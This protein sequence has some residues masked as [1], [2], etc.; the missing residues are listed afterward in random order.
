MITIPGYNLIEK[1]HK[2][3]RTIVYRA[4]RNIDNQYVILKVLVNDSK[5]S[6][7]TARLQREFNII[8][9]IDINEVAQVYGLENY[10]NFTVLVLEDIG[11]QS[12]AQYLIHSEYDLKSLLKIA[13]RLAEIVG[14]IHQKSII[15]KDLKPANIIFNQDKNILKIIDFSISSEFPRESV[16]KR[17]FSELEG[18][19]TYSSP[20]QTGWMNRL[21]DYR[22]DFYTLGVT[23]YQM[24]TGIL[25]FTSEDPLELIHSHLARE[26]V[27]PGMVNS[28]IP[29]ILSLI[30][31]KL[32]SKNPED[33][34]K[35]AAGLKFDLDKCIDQLEKSGQISIFTIGE[36]D[37]SGKFQ[38]PEKL[39][40]RHEQQEMLQNAY[41]RISDKN[42]EL[43][44]ISG[45]PGIGKSALVKQ[46]YKPVVQNSG[47][48]ISGKFEQFN[49]NIPY[50]AFIQAFEDLINQV[51][52]RSPEKVKIWKDKLIQEFGTNLGVI[53]SMV[54]KLELITGTQT[55]KES[56]SL[57]EVQN[58]FNLVM[59]NF[60]GIIATKNNP[61]V[62]FIDDLQ[63]A[64]SSSLKLL[65]ILLTNPE[66]NHILFICAYRTGE[67]EQNPLV[68][69]TIIKINE[70]R[71][72]NLL[73]SGRDLPVNQIS[74]GKIETDTIAEMIQDTFNC[75]SKDANILSEIVS[76]Q[77]GGNPF[78]V[79]QFL[80]AIYHEGLFEFDTINSKWKWDLGKI[81]KAGFTDNIIQ[82]MAENFKKRSDETARILKIASCIGIKF[83]L[84]TLV[85]I[86]GKSRENT[87]HELAKAIR[88][89]FI[90][91]INEDESDSKNLQFQFQHDQ[92]LY[93]ANSLL[94]F[95]E[96]ILLHID[97]GEYNL[98]K[99]TY[100]NSAIFSNDRFGI[101]EN[102]GN[103]SINDKNLY[104]LQRLY[105]S[106]IFSL[107]NHYNSGVE[108]I[109]KTRAVTGL[110][111]LNFLA[112][113]QARNN[114]AFGTAVTYLNF[115][116]TILLENSWKDLYFITL[117]VYIESAE[118]EYINTNFKQAEEICNMVMKNAREVI[119]KIRIFEIIIQNLT[120]Q[121]RF[122]DAIE[123]GRSALN[124]LGVKLPEKPGP[125][126]ALPNIISAYLK[127]SKDVDRLTNL[128]IMNDP[129]K[130]A[131]MDIMVQLITP[132]FISVP[133]L[134]P[135]LILKMI[136]LTLK[137][138]LAPQTPYALAFF[139]M[140]LG[141]G[142]GKYEVGERLANTALKIMEIVP[143]EIYSCKV[144]FA[145]GNMVA[146][147]K[148]PLKDS[149]NILEMGYHKGL[150]SG[151]LL[152]ASY[153]LNWF[154]AY[155]YLTRKNLQQSL[156]E[157]KHYKSSQ[158][159]IKQKDAADFY[160]LWIQFVET[161]GENS[162]ITGYLKG[163][164]FDE[165]TGV[166]IWE[167]TNNNTDLFVYFMMKG[168]LNYFKA[169]FTNAVIFFEEAIPH[170]SGVFGMPVNAEHN[171]FYSLSLLG[172]VKIS[173]GNEKKKIFKKI[174]QNQ[175]K[176]FIWGKNSPENYLHKYLII[177]GEKK[178]VNND[179]KA[180]PVFESAIKTAS[181]NSFILEQAIAN[182]L[183][184]YYYHSHNNIFISEAYLSEA[185]RLYTRWGIP[186]KT[187]LLE[188]EFPEL[189]SKGVLAGATKSSSSADSTFQSTHQTIDL[190]TVLKVSQ[191]I[192]SEIDLDKLT[193]K[194]VLIAIENAGADKG[195]LILNRDK[196]LYLMAEGIKENVKLLDNIPMETFQNIAQ[197]VINYSK[198]TREVV[199]INDTS[200]PNQFQ[201]DPYIMSQKPM[202]IL[203]L[204]V[205]KQLSLIG[206]LYLENNFLTNAFTNERLAMINLLSTQAIISL[207]NAMYVK[208]IIS[209]NKQLENEI[210]D[211]KKTENEL[212]LSKE[213]YALAA[214][215]A[216]DGLWDWDLI[217]ENIYYS[218]R[219]IDMLGYAENEIEDSSGEWF[220]RVHIEDL[221]LLQS[222]IKDHLEGVLPLLECEYRMQHRDGRYLW[223]ITR[224]L[225]IRD[226]NNVAYRMAG[227][228]TEI[229]KR[230]LAEEQLKHDALFDSLTELPNWNLLLD[231]M[232]HAIKGKIRQAE[233]IFAVLFLDVDR[234]KVINDSLGHE[235]GNQLLKELARKL[236][237]CLRPE[238]TVAR[239]G[240][241]E[242]GILLENISD[243]NEPIQIIN[244]IRDST[245]GA[246]HILGHELFIT[247][248]IGVV[249]NTGD[250]L[251]AQDLIRDADTAMHRAKA[252]G[253]NRY[254]IFD[255]T[256]H[257]NI[258]GYLK[259]EGELRKALDK[260][261][262]ILYYQPIVSAKSGKIQGAEAL[263]RWRM[264]S[265]EIIPPGKFIP[266]AEET[267]LILQIGEWVLYE[268]C[269]EIKKWSKNG[270]TDI[271]MSVNI[272][273]N[274]FAQKNFLEIID[275]VISESGINPGILQVEMT[276]SV[277]M[278]NI[279]HATMVLNELKNR[280]IKIAI[281]DFGTGYSSLSYLK[282]F[283]VHKLKIDK[284]FIT[285]MV[286]NS[287][288]AAL[289]KAI[290]AMSESLYMKTIA[291]GVETLEQ[292]QMLRKNQCS[293]I[294][295]YYFSKPVTSEEFF[296]LFRNSEYFPLPD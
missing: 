9:S 282:Q 38:I 199:V 31:L 152:F 211:H 175:K 22:T 52:T 150:N 164:F 45:D 14:K 280:G 82:L 144:Y 268:A 197:G 251:R 17:I 53:S 185:Y 223:M 210:D 46:M 35:T 26:P 71:K 28:N 19:L 153:S 274:Q 74:L 266:L 171:F 225:A 29:E 262:F 248:S 84:E 286:S 83:D 193:Q 124:E 165:D 24:F 114:I 63:W 42:S 106:H 214:R 204:P 281:D 177:E 115:A 203:C 219:W 77:T 242:F 217:N 15:H 123:A 154:N 202:S 47:F 235:V 88:E 187:L 183:L 100:N 137:F 113:K 167:E 229:T 232:N 3:Y 222:A 189:S 56:L 249:I 110:I 163:S 120:P 198:Q 44:L 96:K 127:M 34:Y 10:D 237:V 176:L 267:G 196:K 184:G 76:A 139:G 8:T 79:N 39:Y 146:H 212:I 160:S 226:D 101:L 285:N 291:E 159:K 4:T 191:N 61:V 273:G 236:E 97:I 7:E 64:D 205:V 257:A 108:Y 58:R 70:F 126:S 287:S 270:I 57:M 151:D 43:I 194:L 259:T 230:K 54:P 51:L 13:S 172:L 174:D 122:S 140:I 2:S 128:S 215:G 218:P 67:L 131:A 241:D 117:Q 195:Y 89:E 162:K 272:S 278:R 296:K 148:K 23:F 92:I 181:K 173:S 190:S 209:I 20:E 239:L 231:R 103:F 93:A 138:G 80:S 11:G 250:Y 36:K 94:E 155:N 1:L 182:E 102:I 40:G 119:D 201:S 252:Q 75:T 12:L 289:V 21:I 68:E 130:L 168:I 263:L 221:P 292:L 277:V 158:E 65:D 98:K 180:I 245:S 265:G 27:N 73:S 233:N 104:D 32:L 78:F 166:K 192:S 133:N 157:M 5:T 135:V 290:I 69:K 269:N 55:V 208:K 33:R 87:I 227:S 86:T 186:G 37:V 156:L 116:K 244:R 18:T 294:Q 228:Q 256:M 260:N 60:L 90:F 288:D 125:S 109:P 170:S 111:V 81:K 206:I 224:G 85:F 178:S 255:K 49:K 66:F 275:K 143:S 132:S 216:N 247:L 188:E 118:C 264:E 99:Y 30:I 243:I 6:K 142:M 59:I 295:G 213:R 129:H 149:Q 48:F 279:D 145:I 105:G 112:A 95:E 283:P 254:E 72:N 91:I 234:F 293:E 41:H 271:G 121:N 107:V 134:F 141:S 220:S 238:D 276:E 161:L 169:D 284:S 62:L 25:P 253:R 136:H 258:M 147:W 240:G 16:S 261:E 179:D 50:N 207:E 200:S 246:F